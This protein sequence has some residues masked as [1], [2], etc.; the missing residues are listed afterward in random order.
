MDL[1]QYRG[2]PALNALPREQRFDRFREVHQELMATNESYRRQNRRFLAWMGVVAVGCLVT[3]M[4]ILWAF[5]EGTLSREAFRGILMGLGAMLF[6]A[7][8]WPAARHQR[9]KAAAIQ[10]AF[11]GAAPSPRY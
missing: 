7:V 1:T 11:E 6:V 3:L 2:I 10:H 5:S 8:S 9:L 4:P